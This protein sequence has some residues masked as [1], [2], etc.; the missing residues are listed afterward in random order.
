[1]QSRVAETDKI[2]SMS[3]A[4]L[5]SATYDIFSKSAVLK[6]YEP[7]SQKLI[8]WKDEIGHKPYCYSRLVFEIPGHRILK[9]QTLMCCHMLPILTWKGALK[10]FF[11][12]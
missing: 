5:V 3:P 2:E 9:L 11:L 6:F 7:E 12:Y 8:L 4:M 1:M 10:K